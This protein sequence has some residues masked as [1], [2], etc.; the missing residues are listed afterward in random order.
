MRAERLRLRG[1]RLNPRASPALESSATIR[2]RIGAGGVSRPLAR[3]AAKVYN[4]RKRH[5]G[6]GENPHGD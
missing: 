3:L 6:M 1:G 5:R 4:W 2:F